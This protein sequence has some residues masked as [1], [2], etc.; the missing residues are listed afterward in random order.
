VRPSGRFR[1]LWEP[2]LS[3]SSF[4][5]PSHEVS[6]LLHH[7]LPAMVCCFTMGLVTTGPTNN[8]LKPPKP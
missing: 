7:V 8:G 5:H 3:S 2:G 6:S 4:S 1:V